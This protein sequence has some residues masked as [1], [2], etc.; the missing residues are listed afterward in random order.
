ME[1]N[2]EYNEEIVHGSIEPNTN[3]GSSDM[4][5]RQTTETLLAN[6]SIEACS[7]EITRHSYD[8]FGNSDRVHL[9][10]RNIL[11]IMCRFSPDTSRPY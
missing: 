11:P 9:K 8:T 7:M 10:L 2:Q 5:I 3:N 6:L 1:E 4:C